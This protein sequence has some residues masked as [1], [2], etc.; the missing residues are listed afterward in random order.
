M[1]SVSLS[2]VCRDNAEVLEMML[3]KSR[4]ATV[5]NFK[6]RSVLHV[7]VYEES[8]QCVQVLLKHSASVA[9]QV[10]TAFLETFHVCL[11]F[12]LLTFSVSTSIT[13]SLHPLYSFTV[14]A[15]VAVSP[16]SVYLFTKMTRLSTRFT[17]LYVSH[18]YW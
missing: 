11:L 7:A 18:K 3:A 6:L 5:V 9:V 10:F 8:L 17:L 12:L 4:D 1:Q 14:A 13:V 15:S 2:V 16:H